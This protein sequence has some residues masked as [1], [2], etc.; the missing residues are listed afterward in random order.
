ML[1]LYPQYEAIVTELKELGSVISFK[2][3]IDDWHVTL[4]KFENFCQLS[5]SF[6]VKQKDLSKHV[7]VI[8]LLDL[9]QL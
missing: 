1:C 4:L 7:W 2:R 8:L 6:A 5:E 3:C 9:P